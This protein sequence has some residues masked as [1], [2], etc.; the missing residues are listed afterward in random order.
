MKPSPEPQCEQLVLIGPMSPEGKVLLDHLKGW[1][2]CI[3]TTVGEELGE[4]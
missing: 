3:E 2:T 4:R 1:Q